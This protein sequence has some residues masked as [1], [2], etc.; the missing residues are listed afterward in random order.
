MGNTIG[1]WGVAADASG[2]IYVADPS[3]SRIE[4]F[5]NTGTYITQW[6]SFGTNTGQFGANSPQGIA[7]DSSGN[8]YAIDTG[9][10]RIEIFSSTGIYINKILNSM[11]WS[12]LV[13]NSYGDIY[14]P[15]QGGFVYKYN[16]SLQLV[17]VWNVYYPGGSGNDAWGIAIDGSGY[18]W[19]SDFLNSTIRKYGI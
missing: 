5:S 6:G 14:V 19:I 17:N 7:V 9:N 18:I 2:N 13:V 12:C 4:K 11:A 16:S 10:S 15:T 3:N 1:A 8:I